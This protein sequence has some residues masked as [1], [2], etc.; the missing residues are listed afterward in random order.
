[1]TFAQE[2]AE[3][4]GHSYIGTEHLLLGLMREDA[5]VA[6][7]ALR[8]LGEEL[9]AIR[10]DIDHVLQSEQKR[11]WQKIVPTSRVKRVIE[12]AFDEARRDN[13][14][15]VETGHLIVGLLLEASGIAAHVLQ[16]HGITMDRLRSELRRLRDAGMVE[17]VRSSSGPTL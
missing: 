6:G 8:N 11:V 10:A 15:V 5:G 16:E 3:R 12:I 4:R 17:S 1:M 2:E 14:S 9:P 7:T 13:S